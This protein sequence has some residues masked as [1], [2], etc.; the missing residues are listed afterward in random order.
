MYCFI[1]NVHVFRS[2]YIS[3]S[4]PSLSP[5]FLFFLALVGCYKDI[6]QICSGS[7]NNLDTVQNVHFWSHK[8]CGTFSY[9]CFSCLT[10]SEMWTFFRY[11]EAI[12]R[13]PWNDPESKHLKKKSFI[14]FQLWIC[15]SCPMDWISEIIN[16]T[17]K[18]FLK[19]VSLGSLCFVSLIEIGFFSFK[20]SLFLGLFNFQFYSTIL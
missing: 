11:M 6:T 3:W 14:Q 9:H 8:I 17:W 7:P 18:V 16:Y 19:K 13:Y 4:W 5:F 1:L 10:M 2:N 12:F 20:L 15:Q